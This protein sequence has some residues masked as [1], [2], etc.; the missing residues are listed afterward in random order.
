MVPDL[1]RQ[2]VGFREFTWGAESVLQFVEE[3]KVD[4]NLLILRTVEGTGRRL[5]H[6]ARGIDGVAEKH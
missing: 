6:A 2:H 3:G 1:M 5:R 4:I